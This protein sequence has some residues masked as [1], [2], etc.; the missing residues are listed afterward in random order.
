MAPAR[1]RWRSG[2]GGRNRR[3]GRL[4]AADAHHLHAHLFARGGPVALDRAHD[5]AVLAVPGR[6]RARGLVPLPPRAHLVAELDARRLH[7]DLAA[8][9]QRVVRALDGIGDVDRT[10]RVVA[11]ALLAR[12]TLAVAIHAAH[13]L[14]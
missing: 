2:W 12:A 7:R 14:V 13:R 6:G 9:N 10:H 8:G 5:D 1:G 3:N 4:V 11:V